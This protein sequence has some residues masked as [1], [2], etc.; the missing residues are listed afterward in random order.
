VVSSTV[1]MVSSAVHRRVL[2]G[3]ATGRSSASIQAC[4]RMGSAITP[5]HQRTPRSRGPRP[6]LQKSRSSG[7]T[8]PRGTRWTPSGAPAR[9]SSPSNAAPGRAVNRDR[10]RGH[11]HHP[12]NRGAPGRAPSPRA[13]TTSAPCHPHATGPR[14]NLTGPPRPRPGRVRLAVAPVR[15]RGRSGRLA[16]RSGCRRGGSQGG[17]EQEP[18][19]RDELRAR[20]E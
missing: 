8:Q 13:R 15:R 18:A 9:P 3:S 2:S 12:R 14:R 6:A 20:D 11:H 5:R 17:A 7:R 1:G 19:V 10:V 4:G 16:I